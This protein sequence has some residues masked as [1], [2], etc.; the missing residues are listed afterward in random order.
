MLLLALEV[1]C[2]LKTKR[3]SHFSKSINMAYNWIFF[4]RV[5]A[6]LFLRNHKACLRNHRVCLMI[7]FV[8][9]LDN[10]N[11]IVNLMTD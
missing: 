9:V 3:L 6:S 4:F 1:I 2:T 7:L 10:L 5:C 8:I 11:E